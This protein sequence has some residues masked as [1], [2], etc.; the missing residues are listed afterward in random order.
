[1]R[2][3]DWSSYVCSSDLGIIKAFTIT[4]SSASN[5]AVTNTETIS[6][7][8]AIPNH[9]DDGTLATEVVTR[10]VTGI[11]LTGTAGSPILYVASSDR[12]EERRVGKECGSTCRSRWGAYP[13]KKK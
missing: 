1:M 12:S 10:Q 9:N 6:L 5:Y 13:E 2:I 11:L 7:I 8:N 4:R 3:S